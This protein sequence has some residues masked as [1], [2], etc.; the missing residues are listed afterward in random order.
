MDDLILFEKIMAH[1]NDVVIVTTSEHNIPIVYVNKAF[2]DLTGYTFEEVK[3][4]SPNFLQGA[5]TCYE[6]RD[7]IRAA[8]DNFQSIRATVVNYKKSGE[9]YFIELNIFPYFNDSQ[10][11]THFV[12]I[13]RDVTKTKETEESLM[14][15][16]K[17]FDETPVGLL[18]TNLLSGE[19]LMANYHCV[20]LLGFDSIDDLLKNG[21]STD[22]YYDKRERQKF[23]N[24]MQKSGSVTKYETRIRLRAGRL[25]SVEANMQINCNG[26][27]IE[28]SLINI[29]E[30]KEAELALEKVRNE[31]LAKLNQMNDKLDKALTY[32]K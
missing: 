5:E 7:E 27:S 17:F 30:Q 4:R 32:Y 16:K 24:I 23:I 25:L 3:G 20:E 2:T 21:R 9:K 14:R 8:I 15:Y 22:L 29:T 10:N 28:G 13:E 26:V 11:C 31:G 1:T 19:F 18:R 12:S 6:I